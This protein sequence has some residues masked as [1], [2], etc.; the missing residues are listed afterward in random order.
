MSARTGDRGISSWTGRK[1]ETAFNSR[2]MEGTDW[3]LIPMLF[4]WTLPLR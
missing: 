3:I 4:T 1:R 2:D